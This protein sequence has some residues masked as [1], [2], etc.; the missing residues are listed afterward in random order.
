MNLS[1]W[2]LIALIAP[3]CAFQRPLATFG[4]RVSSS[5]KTALGMVAD[6]AKVVLITGSSQGLGKAM[7]LEMAKYGQKVVVNYIPGCEADAENT[8]QEIKTLGGDTVAIMA[9]CTKPEQVKELFTKAKDHFGRVDVLINNAGVTRDNLVV[10]M[11]QSEWEMVLNVNL[12]GVFYCCQEFFEIAEEQHSG[13]VVN[14]ASVVGQIGNPGQANYA[15]S[16][17]GVIGLTKNFARQYASKGI[18][19]NAI[20]PGFIATPM[21]AKMG[22]EALAAVTKS[23]PLGR[24]GKPEEV[25]A[26]A[27][28]LALDEGADYITGHCFDVDGG[29]GLAAA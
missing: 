20:C 3:S 14:I 4:T 22:E 9:D 27:R 15:A 7:A 13:R 25:A 1:V 18:K 29:V 19:V 28:F 6:D 2:C 16:K 5:T 24:M 23:I 26:M 11:K 10:R 8:V 12:N 17:G 21:T